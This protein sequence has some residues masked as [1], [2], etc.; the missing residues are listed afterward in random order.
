MTITPDALATESI[1]VRQPGTALLILIVA[2]PVLGVLIGSA[3]VATVWLAPVSIV[4]G[5]LV[6]L[7]PLW[8]ALRAAVGTSITVNHGTSHVEVKRFGRRAIHVRLDQVRGVAV[9]LDVERERLPRNSSRTPR[10][11]YGV[12]LLLRDDANGPRAPIALT[13]FRTGDRD[14]QERIADGIA[15]MLRVRGRV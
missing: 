15:A 10:A 6:S 1:R 14:D 7:F 11:T 13:A 8:F 3:L 2:M 12:E 9:A 5:A 4:M